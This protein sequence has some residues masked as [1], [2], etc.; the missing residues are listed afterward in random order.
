[1]IYTLPFGKGALFLNKSWIENEVLG[2]WRLSS[3]FVMQ[4]GNPMGI[5]TGGTNTSYNG[6]GAYTQFPNLV[7]D[8]HISG[9][10]YSRLKEWYNTAAF[11][12]PSAGTYGNAG[13]NIVTGP[14]LTVMNAALGKTFDLYPERGI[15]FELRGEAFNVLNHPSFGQSGSNAIGASPSQNAASSAVI[16]SV[17]VGGRTMQLYGKITF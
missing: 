11:A 14:D 15:R 7:G 17:T 5:T 13:R 16:N 8:W 4:T 3:T 10:N 9:S 12:V 2:G 1:M 6:S